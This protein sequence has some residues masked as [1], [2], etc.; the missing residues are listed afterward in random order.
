MSY[1]YITHP[2]GNLKVVVTSYSFPLSMS[3][4]IAQR[5][6]GQHF[7]PERMDNGTMTMTI[8]CQSEEEKNRINSYIQWHHASA[9]ARPNTEVRIVWPEQNIY[10]SG[11]IT[12]SQ[13]KHVVGEVAPSITLSII[14]INDLLAVKTSEASVSDPFEKFYDTAQDLSMWELPIQPQPE[15]HDRG[16]GG[17]TE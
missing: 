7:L 6:L 11:F 3:G 12:K 14:L 15:R 13:E 16:P 4:N 17:L 5:R 1:A 9:L 10:F 2:Q 8:K